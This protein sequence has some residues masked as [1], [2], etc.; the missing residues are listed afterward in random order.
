MVGTLYYTVKAF[1]SYCRY[2]NK[3]GLITE[4][5]GREVLCN[6]GF[7]NWKKAHETFSQHQQSVSH[8]E[9]VMKNEIMQ[10]ESIGAMLSASVQSGQELNRKLLL[11]QLSSLRYLLRQGLA[12][13]GH[14]DYDGNLVQL[15]MLRSE[16]CNGLNSWL[17][18]KKYMSHEIVNEMIRLMSNYVL[19]EILSEIRE[20]SY[21]SLIVDEC[22]DISHSEQMCVSI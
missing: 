13:R 3:R 2:S 16:D 5:R 6:T 14:T 12:I 4:K 18:N 7:D 21:F 10:Q 1:C 8:R 22:S 20:A 19:R 9:A 11:K 17:Q 15:L